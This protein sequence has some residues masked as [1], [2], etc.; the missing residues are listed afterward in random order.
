MPGI[1]F[2]SI[3]DG[4]LA[5]VARMRMYASGDAEYY[6][7][8]ILVRPLP[9]S[10][11]GKYPNIQ[12]F[13]GV[14]AVPG[15]GYGDSVMA[16][17]EH[18]LQTPMPETSAVSLEQAVADVRTAANLSVKAGEALLVALEQYT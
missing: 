5:H 10:H 14:W 9:S 16:I 15:K 2:P 11:W 3:Y 18:M 13:D 4:V 6:N 12:D 8:R 17:V 1:T 7:E